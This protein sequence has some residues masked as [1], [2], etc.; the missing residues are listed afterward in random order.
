MKKLLSLALTAALLCSLGAPA[1]A[2]EAADTRLS[3]LTEKVKTTLGLDTSAYDKFQGDLEE[4]LITP[5]WR[6]QWSSDGRELNVTST[7]DGRILSY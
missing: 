7:E 3:T 5:V 6:L 2:A 4:N 1:A